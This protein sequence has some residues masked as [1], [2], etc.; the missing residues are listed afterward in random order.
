M[1]DAWLRL[2]DAAKPS[3][4]TSICILPEVRFAV[5]WFA[6]RPAIPN[7]LCRPTS[8]SAKMPAH[9]AFAWHWGSHGD[10]AIR[11]YFGARHFASLVSGRGRTL[12]NRV[13]V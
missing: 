8:T 5:N 6:L 7:A 2:K 3:Y 13:F 12:V 9:S 1:H 10:L 4:V 11:V